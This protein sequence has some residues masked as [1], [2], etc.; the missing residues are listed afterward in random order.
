MID[1]D[2][3]NNEVNL[4]GT[5]GLVFI[6]DKIIVYRRDTKTISFPLQIDLPGGGREKNESPF[7]TFKREVREEFGLTIEKE[8]ISYSK[9][10][11]SSLDPSKVAFFMATRP[12]N[13][14]ERDII[15]GDEGLEF[16]LMTP[17]DFVSLKDGVKRQQDKVAEY[18]RSLK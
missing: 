3:F 11:Q 5:K 18:L 4:N 12:L 16:L 9:K 13:I 10:Y 14:E 7:E 8:D 6:G 1:K 15:F 2:T 17:Q